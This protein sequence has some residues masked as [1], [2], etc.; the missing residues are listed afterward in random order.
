MRTAQE[1]FWAG[2]FGDAYIERNTGPGLLASV[3]AR[4]AKILAHTHGVK[5]AL[6]LGAN[7]GNNM[8]ALH[9]LL[10]NATLDGVEINQ[11]AFDILSQL[12]YVTAHH[13]S[14]LEYVHSTPV[15]LSF[16]SGVLIHID[17]DELPRVYRSLY[18]SSRRYIMVCEYYNLVP[19]EI[20]YRGH[21]GKLF[22]R[23][24]A[25]ELL[26]QY[27]DLKLIDYGFIYH[28]DPTFPGDDLNWFVMEK[29]G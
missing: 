23:D 14:I 15:D 8:K 10:P 22:K 18:E 11:K 29:R 1:Q 28:R 17:P 6:E 5:S 9:T 21:T 26:T 20:V 3:T 25:G 19:V 13:A 7:I 4:W 12:P 24:F 27:P 2:E 16:T